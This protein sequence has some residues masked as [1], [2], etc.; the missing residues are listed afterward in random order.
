MRRRLLPALTLLLAAL[1]C[2]PSARTGAELTTRSLTRYELNEP[3]GDRILVR[4]DQP[5]AG[6]AYVAPYQPI[7]LLS[8]F[9]DCRG[10][11][12]HRG[13]DLAGVG[14]HDG[15]GTPVRAMARSVVI[16]L[17]TPEIDARRY[18]RRLTNRDTV[19]RDGRELPASAEIPGY[20]RVF[21][22]TRNYGSAHTGVMIVTRVLEGPLAGAVLRYM[23]LAAVHPDL[24][25][26]LEL[27][28]GQELGLM[29][30]TAILESR[31][32]VHI[33]AEDAAGQRLDLAP[34]LGLPTRSPDD[35]TVGRCR[36]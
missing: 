22:F 20:G 32:H 28:P 3:A 15:L 7:E 17:G 10:R 29:G 9:W 34:Y 27:H 13:L 31:P 25:V 18:G 5:N 16:E 30:G 33:D 4:L 12:R 11:R 2:A 14:E 19:V 1:A 23:H 36:S 8:D 24:Q 35:P 21:F 26:G 6:A